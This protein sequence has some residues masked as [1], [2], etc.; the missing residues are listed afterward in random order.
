LL[1]RHAFHPLQHRVALRLLT[2]AAVFAV[3][4]GASYLAVRSHAGPEGQATV[5]LGQGFGPPRVPVGSDPFLTG[6]REVTLDQARSQAGFAVPAP[7]S[8]LAGPQNLS[9]VWFS[10]WQNEDGTTAREVILDYVS[11]NIRITIDRAGPGFGSDPR[12][13]YLKEAASLGQPQSSVQTVNS[14]P[15]LVVPPAGGQNGFVD[16][17]MNGIHVAIIGYQP[18]AQLIAIANSLQS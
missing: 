11:S 4:A 14:A 15:A 2:G 17:D 8:S 3:A 5:E 6:G 18:T 9:K 16:L 1:I 10:S 12:A 13:A 7:N